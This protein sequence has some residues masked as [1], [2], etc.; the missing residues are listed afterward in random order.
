MEII[1]EG[2]AGPAKARL[3]MRGGG[4]WAQEGRVGWVVGWGGA[5]AGGAQVCPA[6]RAGTPAPRW[7][8]VW[9]GVRATRVRVAGAVW[10]VWGSCARAA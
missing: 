6:R 7:R 8:V 3:V 1:G 9:C 4:R 2:G 5:A 10:C